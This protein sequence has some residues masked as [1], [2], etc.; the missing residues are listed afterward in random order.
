MPNTN[1]NSSSGAAALDRY[2]AG[3]SLPLL[4]RMPDGENHQVDVPPNASVKDLKTS[5]A[6]LPWQLSDS[7]PQQQSLELEF[8]GETLNDNQTLSHYNIPE[9]YDHADGF[10]KTISDSGYLDHDKKVE[11]LDKACAVVRGISRGE[12]D[13]ERLLGAVFDELHDDTPGSPSAQPSL[14]SMRRSR[15]SRIPSLN[16]GALNPIGVG[17]RSNS[18]LFSPSAPP[19]PRQLMRKLSL[20]RPDLYDTAAAEKATSSLS[21]AIPTNIGNKSAVRANESQSQGNGE[22][23]RGNTWFQDI[24]TTINSSHRDPRKRGDLNDDDQDHGDDVEG[25]SEG[26]NSE[27]L[28]A[29]TDPN[30]SGAKSSTLVELG[31]IL[32][33][34]TSPTNSI[35]TDGTASQP[36]TSLVSKPTQNDQLKFNEQQ[37]SSVDDAKSSAAPAGDS[38]LT[39]KAQG[40]PE[41]SLKVEGALPTSTDGKGTTNQGSASQP[42]PSSNSTKVI[43]GRPIPNQDKQVIGLTPERQTPA[44][45]S[46]EPR[47]PRR[48][49]RKRKNPHLSEEERKAQRQAQNRESAKLSRIRRKHM[50]LEYERRVNSLEGENENLRGTISALEDRLQMLQ[51]LLTISVQRRAI[52]QVHPSMMPPQSNAPMLPGG[53]NRLSAA[54]GTHVSIAGQQGLVPGALNAQAMLANQSVMGRAGISL[55][56]GM[57]QT[58]VP[59]SSQ[60]PPINT[61]GTMMG[62]P[63][64]LPGSAP[65]RQSGSSQSNPLAN[66]R[67]KTF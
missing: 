23:K 57:M 36:G 65:M 62:A 28:E 13:M 40:G 58:Q 32:K 7:D 38:A 33:Q 6:N 43:P 59:G 2:G 56:G 20:L 47:L 41:K 64:T 27:D 10:L 14:R 44:T 42:P 51:N 8:G 15:P 66:L 37:Q 16:F 5:I 52:P 46:Q 48:R 21:L 67:Y 22:L 9:V 4:V 39:T 63:Q 34:S 1:E 60:R 55:H 18:R 17:G 29:L 11:A 53:Q 24:M 19:T 25:N 54:L 45:A 30:A 3:A 61:N 12:K 26:E 50:T 49:G 31:D 35:K